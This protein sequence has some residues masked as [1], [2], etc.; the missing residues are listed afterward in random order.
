MFVLEKWK[1]TD[2]SD[3][4]SACSTCHLKL[5]CIISA[6][7]ET[8]NYTNNDRFLEHSPSLPLVSQSDILAQTQVYV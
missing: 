6:Q 4:I 2:K 8:P 7:L 1:Q 3:I 5:K